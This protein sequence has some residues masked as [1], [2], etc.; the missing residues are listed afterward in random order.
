[1]MAMCESA[2]A[3]ANALPSVAKRAD[4]VTTHDHG[5]GV[6]ELVDLLLEN[7]LAVIAPKLVRHHVAIGRVDDTA[8]TL[9]PYYANL[10]VCGTSGGG[11]S[12]LT[13]SLVEQLGSRGYQFVIA[14]PEGDFNGVKDAVVLGGIDRAPRVSE[15]LDV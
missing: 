14:D 3:V 1:M 9:D 8:I 2:V 4:I 12:T 6:I 5:D 7:D 11:K 15:V 10:V 13:T